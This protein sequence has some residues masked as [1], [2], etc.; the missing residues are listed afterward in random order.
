MY[1]VLFVG[2]TRVV[3][4]TSGATMAS[5]VRFHDWNYENKPVPPEEAPAWDKLSKMVGRDEPL[6]FEFYIAY[7]QSKT[8]GILVAHQLNRL[9][10]K[11]GVYTFA[12][13][14]GFVEST[15]AKTV[16]PH[17]DEATLQAFGFMKTIDQGCSTTMVAGLDPGLK[18]ENGFMLADCQVHM[19][20]CPEWSKSDDAAEK[21][22]KLSE[23]I[24]KEK[25]GQ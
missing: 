6:P 22:W 23:D 16:I 3:V 18:P 8:A 13:H 1:T 10:A 14:P 4:V 21:L 15:G 17:L 20:M 25:L 24:V 2:E 12:V 5:P 7:G 19:E 9:L 11:D